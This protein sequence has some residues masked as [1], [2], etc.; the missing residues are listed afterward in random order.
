MEKK[1]WQM[2]NRERMYEIREFVLEVT[3]KKSNSENAESG[4]GDG[5]KIRS[6]EI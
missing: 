1:T 6:D 5:R 3:E 2:L 4:L